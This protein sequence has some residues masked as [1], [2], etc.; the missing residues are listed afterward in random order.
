MSKLV[1]EADYLSAI[2]KISEKFEVDQNFDQRQDLD[3]WQKGPHK[4]KETSESE[5]IKYPT[6]YKQPPGGIQ[7]E[8][9]ADQLVQLM[10]RL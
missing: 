1:S 3:I 10:G 8:E 2:Q 6:I 5:N 7:L 9:A 4:T